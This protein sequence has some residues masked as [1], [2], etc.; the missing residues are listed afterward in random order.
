MANDYSSFRLEVWNLL[1]LALPILVAQLTGTFVAL[2]D[3]YMSAQAGT[4][5]LAAIALG[6]AYW[7]PFFVF[8]SGFT[9]ALSPLV[10]IYIGAKKKEMIPK[11]MSNAMLLTIII[12]ALSSIMVIILPHLLARP[13]M[14]PIL[15]TK[16]KDYCFWVG[17]GIL[18][19]TIGTLVKNGI[20]GSSITV[21]SMI[22]GFVM[23]GANIPLNWMLIYGHLGL[24]ALGAKGCGIATCISMWLSMVLFITYAK[25]S[26]KLKNR[27][28]F[29]LKYSPI[30]KEILI[31]ILKVGIS[32]AIG[33]VIEVLAISFLGY[34]SAIM[35]PKI[36]AAHQIVNSV[37]LF[38]YV[39]PLAMGTSIAIRIGQ[40]IGLGSVEKIKRSIKSGLLLSLIIIIPSAFLVYSFREEITGLYTKDPEI[41]SLGVLLFNAVFI[42]QLL[43]PF[44]GVGLGIVRGFGD[45]RTVFIGNLGF[46]LC[47][48]V[49]AGYFLGFTDVFGKVYGLPGMWFVLIGAYGLLGTTYWIR[50]RTLLKNA[51]RYI[52]LNCNDINLGM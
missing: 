7:T 31:K 47:L 48:G 16:A 23:V 44:F 10:A 9:L 19:T 29:L 33:T 17:V 3:S 34:A 15:L 50:S 52:E 24:P 35:G 5:D 8:A 22:I 40:N 45:N 2:T 18:G 36:T 30:E 43:D 39:L 25:T 6:G 49:P 13:D 28:I 20:E 46:F 4:E 32:L 37:C 1:K 26:S 12:G 41:F 38:T 11:L 42:Y 27:Q 14:D 51:N 21:P